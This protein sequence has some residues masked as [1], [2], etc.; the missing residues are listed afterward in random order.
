LALKQ[1]AKTSVVAAVAALLLTSVGPAFADDAVKLAQAGGEAKPAAA[2]TE[3]AAKPANGGHSHPPAARDHYNRGV[4]LHRSGF[5]NKAILEYKEAIV[6]D[7]HM[8]PAYSNLGL[9]Y[10]AQKSWS[11]ALEA[12]DKAL[13]MKP[14]RT[15]S[16]NGLGTVLYAMKRNDE[17]MEKWKKAIEIDP[18]FASA[19]Y[20]MGNAYETQE[21][22]REA[23]LAYVKAADINPKM[24][25]AYYRL[26][27]L[28][29]KTKHSPQ[30]HV[31]LS[32]AIKLAPDA[33]FAR[34]AKRQIDGLE[35]QFE[36]D[37]AELS[38]AEPEEA[39]PKAASDAKPKAVATGNSPGKKDEKKN[40]SKMI[41]NIFKKSG[42]GK[43]ENKNVNMFVQPPSPDADLKAKPE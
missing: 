25:D 19:Y 20:N 22:H 41:K 31:L 27:S 17:A 34:D 15:T 32:K 16:L 18:N 24:A 14:D 9:V 6:A 11:K 38:S 28:M 21:K 12:F 13:A 43:E 26:G 8:E 35:K 5:L 39:E 40:P 37:G 3:G 29:N 7:E 2:K 1:N 4:E 36:K 33:E 30:A 10:T 23:L 42:D